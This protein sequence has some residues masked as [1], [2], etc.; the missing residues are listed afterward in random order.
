AERLGDRLP[1]LAFDCAELEGLPGGIR[2][3][4]ADRVGGKGEDLP[5]EFLVPRVLF[6]AGGHLGEYLHGRLAAAGFLT[7]AAL[8]EIVQ[9]SMGQRVQPGPEQAEPGVE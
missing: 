1:A 3:C 2:E 5:L 6:V 8:D 4:R 7:L 9:A